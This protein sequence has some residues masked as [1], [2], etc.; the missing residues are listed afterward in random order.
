[1]TQEAWHLQAHELDHLEDTHHLHT[2]NFERRREDMGYQTDQYFQKSI[3][4]HK[5]VCRYIINTDN[6]SCH[7]SSQKLKDI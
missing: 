7:I 2:E 6:Q 4:S 5:W 1:M 3:S